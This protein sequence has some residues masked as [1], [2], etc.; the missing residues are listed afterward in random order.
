MIRSITRPVC[1]AAAALCVAAATP[2]HAQQGDRV[3]LFS[4]QE[5]NVRVDAALSSDGEWLALSIMDTPATASLWVLRVGIDTPARLTAAGHWDANP[6]WSP[7]GDALY[8]VSNREA[9]AGDLADSYVMALA[10]DAASGRAA[11][12]PRRVLDD[13]VAGAVRV[14]PDGDALAYVDGADRR[15]LKVAP[16][17]GG[18]AKVV[19]RMPERS[20]NIVWSRDGRH[21]Y[22]VTTAP[23][24][25]DRVLYRVPVAG[26]E[27]EVVARGLPL[28]RLVFGPGAET[29]V[30]EDNTGGPRERTLELRD[31]SGNVL[32]AITTN[33]RTR[34]S[35]VTPDGRGM[36]AVESNTVAPT[37]VMPV[38]GGAYRDLTPP[39]QYEW[40]MRWSPEGDA[41]YTWTERDGEPVLAKIPLHEA[42]PRFFTDDEGWGSEG[43][44]SRF[45]FL[46]SRRDGTNPRSL[47]AMDLHHG[48]RH[49]V[50]ESLPALTSIFPHGPGGAWAAH[51]EL[52]YFE[53]HG[54]EIQVRGWRGP[55][56]ARTVRSLP[57][58]LIGRTN[59]AVHG[60]RVAWQ[61][62][63]GEVLDLMI[64]DSPDAEPRRLLTM[65]AM[66]GSNE[67]SFSHDGRLL[68]LHYSRGPG[69]PD[70]M[71]IVDAAGETEPR[72]IDPGLRYWYWPRWLPDDS[73]VL[74]I[75][76]GAGA[77]SN[78]VHVPVAEG[79]EIVQIT[80]EDTG[81][82]WGFEISPDGSHI[83]YPGEVYR[84]ST[85]W[86]YSFVLSHEEAS[87]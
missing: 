55:G 5:K 19:T 34:A 15:M 38:T 20:G 6:E 87:R 33:R 25:S 17:A 73:G 53:R 83:A 35:L 1:I 40:V 43:A 2:A 22:F 79:G 37:R 14:S 70:L 49:T 29:Y 76:G 85:V 84:G 68:V 48:T 28:G 57:A 74:A 11:G 9:A 16:V 50:S 59:V 77:E 46:A 4:S 66:P 71:A 58:S 54:D 41:V 23:D 72:I 13:P 81:S 52:F 18:A 32:H 56:E 80:R 65:P 31:R 64:A 51:E 62:P 27:L 36:I 39:E 26:G 86:R 42:E 24:Q 78:V 12:E 10:F 44:N 61:Q 3:E 47:V 75:G 67:I 30:W 82:V 7:R 69:S 60:D 45:L 63:R 8:F 21:L